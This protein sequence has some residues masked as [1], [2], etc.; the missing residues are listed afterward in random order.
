MLLVSCCFC[1]EVNWYRKINLTNFNEALPCNGSNTN[2]C[3]SYFPYLMDKSLSH[4]RQD[5]IRVQQ[6][7]QFQRAKTQSYFY[8]QLYLSSMLPGRK[9]DHGLIM[10]EPMILLTRFGK[11][12]ILDSDQLSS[13]VFLI[14]RCIV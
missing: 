8:N 13:E 9:T 4:Q 3:T 7:R 1:S 6:S 12:E 5:L 11:F 10:M 14:L 2:V